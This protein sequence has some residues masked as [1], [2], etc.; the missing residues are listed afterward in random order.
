MS[1]V[2][3]IFG[4]VDPRE[5]PLYTVR[6][7]AGYLG[8]PASTVRA[9]TVG[10]DYPK[11]HGRTGRFQP[12]IELPEGRPARLTFNNLI[13]AY[14]LRTL[15]RAH[16]VELSAV[17]RA[18]ANVTRQLG[19]PRPLLSRNFATDGVRIYLKEIDGL[20]EVSTGSGSQYTIREVIEIGLTRIERSPTG[21]AERLYPYRNNVDEPKVVAIDPRTSFGRPTIQ[22]SGVTVDVVADLIDAGETA[23][24]VAREFGIS[25]AEVNSAVTWHKR[26]AA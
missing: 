3:S 17:R 16:N 7:A 8:D 4:D 13:E 10:Q 6:Q 18:I 24:R 12:L 14:V 22:G 26:A 1:N 9:W 20:L 11:V 19:D 2:V 25:K 21:L 5:V 23:E 15:R